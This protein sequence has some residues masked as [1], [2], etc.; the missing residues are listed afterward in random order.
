MKDIFCKICPREKK[1]TVIYNP[2]GKHVSAY[3]AVCGAFIKHM[4]TIE[5]SEREDQVWEAKR[6][7]ERS[8]AIFENDNK[9]N[10]IIAYLKENLRCE[11]ISDKISNSTH[12]TAF[13]R[14]EIKI[15]LGDELITSDRAYI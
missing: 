5:R 2:N 13:I 8:Q 3:C 1:I 10:Q 14:L 12:S 9:N 11:L 6:L 4:N 15:L 7:A